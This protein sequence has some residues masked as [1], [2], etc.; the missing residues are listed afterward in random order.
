MNKA[1]IETL[2]RTVIPVINCWLEKQIGLRR[3]MYRIT[4]RVYLFVRARHTSDTT[5]LNTMS[6]GRQGTAIQGGC[7]L[8]SRRGNKKWS[9]GEEEW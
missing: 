1:I 9:G 5:I 2:R 3:G 8:V 7:S 6:I 4:R